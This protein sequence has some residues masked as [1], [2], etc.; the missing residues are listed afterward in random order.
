[1]KKNLNIVAFICCSIVYLTIHA[2]KISLADIFIDNKFYGVGIESHAF[3]NQQEAYATLSDRKITTYNAQAEKQTT[4]DLSNVDASFYN[5]EFS[6]T[7]RYL[8]LQSDVLKMYRRSGASFYYCYDTKQKTSFPLDEERIYFPTF[9]N[10]DKQVA[11]VKD[12]NLYYKK[13]PNGKLT[14]V[15]TDGEWNNIINGKSDWAYEEEW[16]MTNAFAWSNNAQYLAY[17]KFDES[18]VKEY[19]LPFYNN[20]AYTQIFSYKY[21]KAGAENSKV[22]VWIYD[23]NK[24]KNIE[25]NLKKY[26]YEYIPRIY[27]DNSNSVYLFLF[28]RLQNDFK[29]ISYN[30]ENNKIKT[31]YHEQ[32]NTY[33]EIPV[34]FQILKDNS[35][36]IT[37]EKE[38]YNNLYWYN[39]EG[40]LKKQLTN[41]K[42]NITKLYGFDEANQKIYFQSNLKNT[43]E[44]YIEVLDT[45]TNQLFLLRD[46]VGTSEAE[47]SPNF[48]FCF[49]NNQSQT[50]PRVYS[51]IDN[52]NNT[53]RT[54]QDNH[55]LRDYVKDFPQKEFTT[56]IVNN[57]NLA[58]W[59]LKPKDFDSTKQYPLLMYVYNGP[60]Y[61]DV[62]N[63]FNTSTERY[64]Y[65][66]VSIGYIVACV[67]GRGTG[68]K[69]ANFK[70][71]TY[72]QLGKYESDDQIAAAQYF[73]KLPFIDSSRIGIFGW[74]YGGFMSA[75]C[76]LKGNTVF[77][78]AIAVASV[79]N[80]K[81]YDNVYTERYMQRP[82]DNPD[83]YEQ[84]N[85]M[86]LADQLKGNLLLIHGSA[87][88]NVHIQNTYELVK[89]LNI[90]EKEYQ[91]LVYLDKD[92]GIGGGNTRY[93]LFN[94]ITQFILKNL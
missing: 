37:S 73:G 88:D 34:G 53:I 32:S 75:L 13:I 64:V 86:N 21:P 81:F 79:T 19:Y 61:Q 2:Q 22:S 30:V 87:D 27:W 50:H 39:E 82:I 33:V 11:F 76:L 91:L 54:L 24:K 46:D 49:Y 36:F 57:Q 16:E 74:S 38:G 83:G 20:N 92:H 8:L 10:D 44:K 14:A 45:K 25:V 78:A 69:D 9:S 67:D 68:G 23:T 94:K 66:L 85:L 70:K 51:I 71:C 4:L 89:A 43:Y 31:I 72:K 6:N 48:G 7:D 52:K 18:Q 40:N 42:Y 55:V 93:D 17:L 60:G 63:E 80:W 90:Q 77:K 59:I 47:F 56:I 65:Y 84:S 58:T 5:F 1:M 15:T 12:N 26:D 3:L 62:L 41:N 28:N 35:F 29:I